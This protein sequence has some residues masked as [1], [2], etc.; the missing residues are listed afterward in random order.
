M[1][2]KGE[3]VKAVELNGVE[4]SF[5]DE[6][7]NALATHA[8]TNL[9]QEVTARRDADGLLNQKIET[10][11][12]QRSAL[13]QELAEL[14]TLM[15]TIQSR[16]NE[17]NALIPAQASEDNQLADKDFVNSSVA[18][19]TSNFIGTFNTLEE[20]EAQTATNN[21]YAFWKTTDSDGNVVFKRYKYV[22]DDAAWQ[23]EYDLNNSSFTAEQWATINSGLTAD[24][25]PTK[26]SQLVNDNN[27]A[28][29]EQVNSIGAN[30]GTIGLWGRGRFL[31]VGY[32]V[33]TYFPY[34]ETWLSLGG[35]SCEVNYPSSSI[36][37]TNIPVSNRRFN[38]TVTTNITGIGDITV[39][40]V[41]KDVTNG[42]TDNA[43]YVRTANGTVNTSMTDAQVISALTWSGWEKHTP[44]K[45]FYQ[46]FT[47]G[48][49]LFNV[50]AGSTI[51]TETF[52]LKLSNLLGSYGA[53]GCIFFNYE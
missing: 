33:N 36:Q 15:Q 19:N 14:N 20:L 17:L 26:V 8:I 5:E 22:A 21:D 18:T 29:V 44:G 39:K 13:A 3:N 51:S 4:H 12:Q 45:M 46:W 7:A 42:V 11:T 41:A 16:M 2:T 35:W 37:S 49:A 23:F 27:Y 31:N 34:S 53:T 30:T 50:T 40:Q 47:G 32:D 1:A 52:A 9:G 38:I 24:S 28:S 6:I 25:I 10:E 43:L 48:S